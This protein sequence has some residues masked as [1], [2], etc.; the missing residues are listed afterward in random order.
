M[1]HSFKCIFN[2]RFPFDTQECNI[3]FISVLHGN[4]GFVQKIKFM[5]TQST[6][7]LHLYS[8]NPGWDLIK[9]EVL[10]CFMF[11]KGFNN[12]FQI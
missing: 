6:V 8:E 3:E 4:L 10:H 2:S 11:Q 12:Y 9:T 1:T 7:N 5:L